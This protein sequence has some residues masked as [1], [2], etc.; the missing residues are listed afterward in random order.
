LGGGTNINACLFV[1]PAKDDFDHWPKYWRELVVGEDDVLRPRIMQ[2]V[3]Q[4][5]NVMR[6]NGAIIDQEE[7][8]DGGGGEEGA[9]K[10][11]DNEDS[12]TGLYLNY[13]KVMLTE[14]KEKDDNIWRRR[15][16]LAKVTS[17]IRQKDVDGSEASFGM[18]GNNY[19]RVNYYQGILKPLLDEY[20][21]LCESLHFFTGVL[22]ERIIMHHENN[23]NMLTARGVECSHVGTIGERLF[24]ITAKIVV[25]CAGAILTPALLLASGIGGER[26]LRNQG[27]TPIL[28]GKDNLWNGVGKRLCDHV[29]AATGFCATRRFSSVDGPNSVRGWLA[30]DI[31]DN[32]SRCHLSSSKHGASR[33]LLKVMDGSSSSSILP[34][35]IASTCHRRYSFKPYFICW[36]VNSFLRL[37]SNGLSLLVGIMLSNSVIFSFFKTQTLQIL[38]CLMNPTSKGT[39]SIKQRGKGKNSYGLNNFDIQIDPAYLSEEEDFKNISLG[40]HAVK[41]LASCWIPNS[42]E[43]LPGFLYKGIGGSDYLRKYV[44]DFALPYYHWSGTCSMKS[45]LVS[46][47]SHVVDE[48]LRVRMITNLYICDASVHPEIISAPPAL[49]LA[50]MGLTASGILHHFIRPKTE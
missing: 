38:I 33:L 31:A 40:A 43:V 30:M 32:R 15:W 45:D 19:Q 24:T 48:Q 39:V 11:N 20:P 17:T 25:V 13:E 3:M 42:I 46:E 1:K 23:S 35:V 4:I 49:T 2:S 50:A 8:R 34:G 29:I 10:S 6:K 22:A 26:E 5:E 12:A 18:K 47:D 9:D 36:F 28:E 14:C 44:S 7:E 27:V 37:L 41:K 16:K 21:K